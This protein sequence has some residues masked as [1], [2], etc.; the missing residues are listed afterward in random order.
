MKNYFKPKILK[1][2]PSILWPTFKFKIPVKKYWQGSFQS[3]LYKKFIPYYISSTKDTLTHKLLLVLNFPNFVSP[4]TTL[5]FVLIRFD[6]GMCRE[7]EAN[8]NKTLR[9]VLTGVPFQIQD[10]GCILSIFVYVFSH[11]SKVPKF[12]NCE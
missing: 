12:R 4:F 6:K 2:V 5:S 7:K 8:P 1:H 9:K 3:Q 11:L 10:C